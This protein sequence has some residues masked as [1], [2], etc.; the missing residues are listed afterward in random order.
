MYN[1]KKNKVMDWFSRSLNDVF[2]KTFQHIF[3]QIQLINNENLTA[4]MNL[5]PPKSKPGVSVNILRKTI[6]QYQQNCLEQNYLL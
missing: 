5:M 3:Y 6:S 2:F 1:I 4:V